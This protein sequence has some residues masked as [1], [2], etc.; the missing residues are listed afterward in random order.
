MSLYDEVFVSVRIE[1]VVLDP[2]DEV[3]G[4][5]GGSINDAMYTRSAGDVAVIFIAS[6]TKVQQAIL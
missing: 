5:V 4:W 6:P 3:F 2:T 1:H